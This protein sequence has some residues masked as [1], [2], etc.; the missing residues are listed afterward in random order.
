MT[1][2]TRVMADPDFLC[3]AGVVDPL[4]DLFR[5]ENV[6]I[7]R[8]FQSG[9]AAPYLTFPSCDPTVFGEFGFE[10]M[11]VTFVR[12]LSTYPIIGTSYYN[13]I[14]FE[15][16]AVYLFD[17][18]AGPIPCTCVRSGE[19]SVLYLPPNP[20]D[21]PQS[22]SA[23]SGWGLGVA[24]L[25]DPDVFG[26]T[27]ERSTFAATASPATA[28]V[29]VVS[30]LGSTLSAE[31]VELTRSTRAQPLDHQDPEAVQVTAAGLL[32][33]RLGGAELSVNSA[34]GPR[35]ERV[36]GL[37]R[38]FAEGEMGQPPGQNP[39]AEV[40]GGVRCPNSV[41]RVPP[42]MSSPCSIGCGTCEVQTPGYRS[43]VQRGA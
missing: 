21:S 33:P 43:A 34:A 39:W 22:W 5:P 36:I 10:D 35:G 42:A 3:G 18:G 41:H 40:N 30:A 27:G 1:F 15:A 11:R 4:A 20:I 17:T 32:Y 28:V 7:F 23:T 14:S 9:A 8:K 12:L 37:A 19:F 38:V 16:H 2:L 31:S 24:G 6:E 26:S 25:P 13:R 29:A